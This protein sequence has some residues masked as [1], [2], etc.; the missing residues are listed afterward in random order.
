MHNSLLFLKADLICKTIGIVFYFYLS[1]IET[2]GIFKQVIELTPYIGEFD[3][4]HCK[5]TDLK[6][7]F[8]LNLVSMI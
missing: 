8:E 1:K 7:E 5:V 3:L 4:T 2:V 6:F